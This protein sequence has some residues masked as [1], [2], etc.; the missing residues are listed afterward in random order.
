MPIKKSPGR[1]LPR[2]DSWE[3]LFNGTNIEGLDSRVGLEFKFASSRLS[4]NQLTGLYAGEGVSA[5]IVDIIPDTMTREWFDVSGDTNGDVNKYLSDLHA[6]KKVNLALRWARLYGGSIIIIGAIDGGELEEELLDDRISSID[7]LHVFERPLVEPLT[8]YEDVMSPKYQ[9]PETYLVAPSGLG[10][11]TES[12]TVHESRILRFDGND[13]PIDLQ[14]LNNGWGDSV[15][16]RCYSRIKGLANSYLSSETILDEFVIGVLKMKGLYELMIGGQ[17]AKVRSRLREVDRSKSNL[18][19]V[20]IDEEE[21]YERIT[22]TLTGVSDLLDRLGTALCSVSQIPFTILF[23]RSP[24]GM[25]ATGESDIRNW[26]D[27]VANDQK[28]DMLPQCQRL[29]DLTLL[30]ADG[31]QITGDEDEIGKVQLN[32]LWQESE[33]VT[34]KNREMQ[35]KSDQRYYDIGV[36]DSEEIRKS[37]FAGEEYSYETKLDETGARE[38]RV[39]ETTID[40]EINEPEDA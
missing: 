5:R 11:S 38:Q 10:T 27:S 34:I 18:N 16:Q 7:F 20:I 35:S 28:Y 30:S 4:L 9:Q 33:E 39:I 32:P 36:L 25:N 19:S 24:A 6:Q 15:L 2:A 8:W 37:R 14:T 31:P 3:N 26:Y 21:S 22:S 12:I 29:V 23:G 17:E 40:P 13:I 1:E